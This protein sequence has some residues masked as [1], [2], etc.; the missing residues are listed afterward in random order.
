MNDTISVTHR[1]P[2]SQYAYIE[3]AETVGSVPEAM[4]NHNYYISLYEDRV[5]LNQNQWAKVR[6]NMLV[7]GEFDPNL[8]DEMSRAQK[9]FVNELKKALR[10]NEAADPVIN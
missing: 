1:V 5:G 6:N 9:Y 3:F 7:T 8:F 10:A 2:T 4:S